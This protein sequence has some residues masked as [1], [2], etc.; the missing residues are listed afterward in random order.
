MLVKR[1]PDDWNQALVAPI[2]KKGDKISPANYRPISITSVCY[3]IMEHSQIMHHL[4]EHS[5]LSDAQQ[6]SSGGSKPFC[7][8]SARRSIMSQRLGVKLCQY[9]ITTRQ[10]CI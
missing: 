10:E 2:F 8:I 7:L 4:D 6:S 5:I 1:P 9:G 3:K